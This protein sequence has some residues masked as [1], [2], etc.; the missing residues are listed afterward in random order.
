MSLSSEI[1]QIWTFTEA[2]HY[3]MLALTERYIS[4]IE[5]GNALWRFSFTGARV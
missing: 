3:M 4:A 1:S 5:Q 2:G